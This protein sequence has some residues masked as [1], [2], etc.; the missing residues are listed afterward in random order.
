MGTAGSAPTA[1]R[2]VEFANSNDA[3]PEEPD[4]ENSNINMNKLKKPGPVLFNQ[5]GT[6]SA[7]TQLLRRDCACPTCGAHVEKLGHLRLSS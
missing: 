5:G 1:A 2:E 3:A 6:L 7:F 4:D